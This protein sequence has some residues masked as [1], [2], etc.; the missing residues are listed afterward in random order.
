M[1]L[2]V[3]KIRINDN[4]ISSEYKE[5]M[6]KSKE[7]YNS[8]L[9]LT[10]FRY[11]EYL[12]HKDKLDYEVR[13]SYGLE[14][15][16]E[17]KNVFLSN[18][19]SYGN[20]FIN[21]VGITINSPLSAKERQTILRK[22]CTDWKA[23]FKTKEAMKDTGK[24][25][26]I[27]GYKEYSYLVCEFNEQMIKFLRYEKDHKIGLIGLKNRVGLPLWLK[28]ESIQAVRLKYKNTYL[29]LEV[30][31]NKNEEKQRERMLK[32]R[33]AAIDP[34]LNSIATITFN[35]LKKPISI[36]GKHLKSVNQ[37]Y[38]KTVAQLNKEKSEYKKLGDKDKVNK[39]NDRISKV[40]EKRNLRIE[41]E[42]HHISCE[43]VRILVRNRVSKLIFGHNK[44]QKEEINIGKV[45]NQNFVT[46]PF[47]Q[48]ITY[49]DY[50]CKEKSIAF[51]IQ[52]ESYTSKASFLSND[53]IPTF[54]G[55]SNKEYPFSGKRVKRGKYIDRKYGIVIHSDVNGS[56][57]IMRKNGVNLSSLQKIFIGKK[58][59]VEPVGVRLYMNK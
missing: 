7:F 15:W 11:F 22:V 33:V 16:F 29:Y 31:Y 24:K 53:K 1:V 3:L 20:E 58:Q 32:R 54:N 45:N 43:I 18:Y 55:N 27:P 44:G 50:K 5:K 46:I 25:V 57:N 28:R 49:L 14:D 4:I 9:Y 34:G 42:L 56:Y 26:N 19:P 35:Y 47:N 59:T 48:L 6:L 8:C 30:V 17:N 37:L 23:Y 36:S 51:E 12:G 2:R 40:T 52:E 21:K 10:R 39:I 13:K 41:N 38:N